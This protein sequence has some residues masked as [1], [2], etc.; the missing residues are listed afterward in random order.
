MYII[1]K[2]KQG[3]HKKFHK[4]KFI[5]KKLL[6]TSINGVII[7]VQIPYMETERSGMSFDRRK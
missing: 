7:M 5:S 3:Q 2:L 1:T 4:M 6:T